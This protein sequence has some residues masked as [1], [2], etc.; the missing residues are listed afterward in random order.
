MFTNDHL[1]APHTV[2][3]EDVCGA[4]AVNINLHGCVYILSLPHKAGLVA[5][6]VQTNNVKS[7]WMGV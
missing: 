4:T 7:A 2:S 5:R 3:V 6:S 1:D